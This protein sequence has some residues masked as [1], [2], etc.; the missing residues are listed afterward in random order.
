[1]QDNNFNYTVLCFLRKR[2]HFF[3]NKKE[4]KNYHKL[5]FNQALDDGQSTKT[6]IG[7]RN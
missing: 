3:L 4:P 7:S 5:A 6:I 1:M 2:K